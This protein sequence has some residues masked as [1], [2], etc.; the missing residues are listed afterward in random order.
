MIDRVRIQDCIQ[1]N[2]R[3]CG[4]DETVNLP[5]VAS[6][7]RG[8]TSDRGLIGGFDPGAPGQFAAEAVRL[9]K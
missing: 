4:R 1:A 7:D 8:L 9:V 5:C 2:G 3:A 6:G